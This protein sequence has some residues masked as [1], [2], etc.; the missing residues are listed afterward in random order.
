MSVVVKPLN[1][2]PVKLRNKISIFLGGSI[3]KGTSINWQKELED[4]LKDH[5]VVIYNPRRDDWDNSWSNAPIPGS[6]FYEQVEWELSK[7]EIAK[8]NIYC[9][10]GDGIAPIS[11]L[12]FGL[13]HH[14]NTFIY[15]DP[16]YPRFGNVKITADRYSVPFSDDW[17]EFK[18]KIVK[19]INTVTSS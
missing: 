14:K 18:E 6:K 5:D 7:Q 1:S 10:V 8:I 16:K 4:L 9:L 13:F 12:E 17:D 19:L 11:L 3:N 2:I 15:C